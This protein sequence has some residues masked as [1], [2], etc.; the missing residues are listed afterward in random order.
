MGHVLHLRLV[1]KI[2]EHQNLGCD[3]SDLMSTFKHEDRLVRLVVFKVVDTPLHEVKGLAT[4]LLSHHE[5]SKFLLIVHAFGFDDDAV[6]GLK[7]LIF[8]Q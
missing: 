2:E 3:V 7:D 8:W 4:A 5:L 6:G 1:L